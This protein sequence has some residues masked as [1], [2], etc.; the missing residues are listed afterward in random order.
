[1][2]K[3]FSLILFSSLVSSK[4]FSQVSP[5]WVNFQNGTGDN[6]DRYNAVVSDAAGNIYAA[7]YSYN[8]LQDKDFLIVKMNSLGDTV[9]TRQYNNPIGN[10]SDKALFIAL[11]GSN[12]VYVCGVTDAGST[13]QNDILTQKYSNTGIFQWSASY[14]YA[15]FN[16]DDE[17][18]GLFVNSGG[19]VFVTGQS[20][21]DS[22]SNTNDDIITIKYNTSGVQQWAVRYNGTG[23]GTD[24][25]TAITGDNSG[26]CIITGR[27][28]TAV[29]DDIITIKYSSAGTVTWQ[30]IYNRGFGND[31][32]D[33]MAI[34]AAGNIYVEGRSQNATDY[35][36]ATLKYNSAGALQWAKFYQNLENDYGK[37]IAVDAAGNVYVAGQSDVNA[38]LSATNYDYV[39][40]MYNSAGTQLWVQ[41]LGNAALNDEDPGK[42]LVDG[43]GN[44]FVTG[45]SDVNA[46]AAI[47]ANNFLTV[48]Y[49]SAGTQQ[50]A[51][52]LD[53]TA[54]NSD[55]IA[56][57]MIFDATGNVIVVGG[58]HNLVTQKDAAIVK[59]ATVNGSVTWSKTYNGKGDFSDKVN[60]IITDSKKNIYITG[61]VI[62]FEAKKD[63]FCA[64][65]NSNGVTQW[66]K[67]YDFAF[68][69][70]EGKAIAIDTLG[71]VYVCGSS[72]GSG[73]SD[74]YIVIKYDTLGNQLWTY[75]YN[76]VNENDIATSISVT[77]AG[78]V[79]VTGYSDQNTSNLVSNYDIATIKLSS[80]GVQQAIV[81]YNGSGNGADRAV[82]IQAVNATNIWV[83]GRV[84]NGTNEDIA[85]IKYNGS[86]VQQWI[87]I[88]T[89][90]GFTDQ[91]RDMFVDGSG[92]SFIAG[93]TGTASNSDDYVVVKYNNAGTQQ[94]TYTY[95]GTGSYIDRAYSIFS[96]ANGVYLTGRSAPSS[97]ADSAD[98]VTVKLNTST[99]AQ[100]WLNRYNGT[101]ALYDRGNSVN[102]NS[103]GNIFVTGESIG[104]GSGYDFITLLYDDGG[105]I[106]SNMRYNG[107]GNKDDAGR[108]MT[109]DASGSICAA[110]FSTGAGTSG[111]D[112]TTLKICPPLGAPVFSSGVTYVCRSQTGFVYSIAP[113][114]GAVS[115]TWTV[116]AGGT[117]SSGQGTTS[118]S[119]DFSASANSG[120]VTV[121]AN[122]TCAS[123]P[124]ATFN[125][126]VVLAKPA[127]PGTISG[128]VS[129]C[130]G[131]TA[132]YSITA[133]AYASSY[134]WTA[135]ANTTILSGQGTTSIT[136]SFG[137]A[138][139][140]GTLSVNAS[141]CFGTSANRTKSLIS[142]P[143]VPAPMTGPSNGVCPGTTGVV[144][145][146]TAVAY[147]TSYVWTAP[148]NATITSGQGT[149]SV[150]VDFGAAWV[151][152]NLNVSSINACG[153]SA[154]RALTIK[155]VPG[156][157]TAI[158]GSTYNLC[159]A[160]NQNYS[161][162]VTASATSYTWTVP[163][164]TSIVSGQGTNA[165]VINFTNAFVTGIIKVHATNGCGSSADRTLTVYAKPA[166]PGTI[167]GATTVCANQTSVPYSIAAVTGATS[168]T[169]AVPAGAAIASGQGTNSITVN[170]GTTA[171]NVSVY[172]TNACANSTTKTLAVTITC[173]EEEI[174]NS[175]VVLYP[176][177]ATDKVTLSFFLNE[178]SATTIELRNILG[179]K[180]GERTFEKSNR[181]AEE[182]FDLSELA[183]GTY[184]FVLKNE[185]N[186]V[187]KKFE[188]Q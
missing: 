124:A 92:N 70:D 123:S 27:T 184:L 171:G 148:A 3:I 99:G 96:N 54:T 106:I 188:L 169:W 97:G 119:V 86:L 166:T 161:C 130:A 158:T 13:Y 185:N 183:K 107:A 118:I 4:I 87:G 85:T 155:S 75:R 55:D 7:G 102:S 34:D 39:T 52:Y 151:T 91:P 120:S 38:S 80:A 62:D 72:I 163:A 82:K 57:G 64:K 127:T 65:L 128:G 78:T 46:A 126:Q 43:S 53:G 42:I 36:V 25:G 150:T 108:A 162:T 181:I 116:S 117:I 140:T 144:Y 165:V 16:Q 24:R 153:T 174:S 18:L 47:T 44:V 186:V 10:G 32:A 112:A 83:T 2:K 30:Q 170:F 132:V 156:I 131:T 114:S 67:T 58:N 137:S 178:N 8:T 11:D 20:D 15:P 22:S 143:A 136:L 23:N 125:Y 28:A 51:V 122:G 121:V 60:A 104:S 113:V 21:A 9:W 76:Y 146:I 37:T 164:N 135:P 147:A 50:W 111:F 110:G 45:K 173:R 59:Y 167:T 41:F 180:L 157:P 159:N 14:N 40:L 138:W 6:S 187:V 89:G 152:G 105:N 49:N 176:N 12:N 56:E 103:L 31:R 33:D 29:D 35:D 179:Q 1:M 66:F 95:N 139:V 77:T 79:F 73:T 61:Y 109:V 100:L 134:T 115:Y 94:W 19:E 101:G 93:N 160:G 48:K 90:A 5:Q 63:L 168:Y 142:K 98:V 154:P 81:R 172:A 175:G 177:P 182:V 145:T 26:G 74:D 71:G 133:V 149:T 68:D 129:N 69:D 141:N 88:Y 84:W 17:P